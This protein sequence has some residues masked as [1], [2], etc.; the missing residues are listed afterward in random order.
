MLNAF[1]KSELEKFSTP[2][3]QPLGKKIIDI[4]KADGS[5]TDYLK[6]L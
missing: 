4:C 2:D 5:V 1:F 3:L 6:I